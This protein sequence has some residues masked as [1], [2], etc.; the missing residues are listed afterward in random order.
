MN[1]SQ[2]SSYNELLVNIIIEELYR[3]KIDNFFISPGSRS[4]PL[5]SSVAYNKNLST[6]IHL[7]ERGASFAAL[8]YARATGKPGVLICTSGSAGANYYPAICEASA[9]SIPM[10]ILTADRPPELH[11]VGANQTCNQQY[12]FGQH[13]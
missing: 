12:L 7:D 1:L 9:D 4:T 3:H 13:V 5:T 11:D 10:I 8:G 6:H 2:A